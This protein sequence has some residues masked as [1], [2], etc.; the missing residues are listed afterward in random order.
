[1]P[2]IIRGV[3]LGC[4]HAP[5]HDE[6]VLKEQIA[7]IRDI[8]PNLVVHTGDLFDAEGAS[9]GKSALYR[10]SEAQLHDEYRVAAT[11]LRRIR[12]AAPKAKLVWLEGNH[13]AR[14]RMP[15]RVP[16]ALI[17]MLDYRRYGP[18]AAEA[19]HWVWRPYVSPHPGLPH[20]DVGLYRVGQITFAH[21][22]LWGNHSDGHEAQLYGVEYGLMVR[23][24]THKPQPVTRVMLTSSVPT[25]RWSAN[26]GFGGD[27]EK[28]KQT[29]AARRNT[30]LWGHGVLTFSTPDVRRLA[31]KRLWQANLI[32]L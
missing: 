28:F 22:W 29:Y 10:M 18:L 31:P 9:G 25:N 32:E 19:Q 23:S 1:M 11:V 3:A 4:T 21:G 2:E 17:G 27:I 14:V 12:E 5:Y 15:E 16:K 20:K 6:R 7:I 26:V 30:A 24:H 8:K 13:E